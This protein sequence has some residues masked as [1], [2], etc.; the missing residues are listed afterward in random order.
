[1]GE[2]LPAR[3][4]GEP[5]QRQCATFV[6]SVSVIVIEIGER[7]VFVPCGYPYS[8]CFRTAGYPRQMALNVNERSL[9]RGDS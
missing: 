2:I 6:G 3:L 8:K 5:H 4:R 9:N 1:M 7:C